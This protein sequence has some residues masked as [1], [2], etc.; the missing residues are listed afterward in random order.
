MMFAKNFSTD[1]SR[2]RLKYHLLGD[3]AMLVDIPCDRTEVTE[4]NGVAASKGIAIGAMTPITIKGRVRNDAGEV[5]T[6]FNGYAKISRSPITS[7]VFSLGIT[8]LRVPTGSSIAGSACLMPSLN[9]RAAA[10]LNA[11]SELSTGW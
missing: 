6:D 1:R 9:A 7:P 4:V 10:V 8:A 2:N 3:P 5:D 11:I